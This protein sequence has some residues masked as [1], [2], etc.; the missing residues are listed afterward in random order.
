M[1]SESIKTPCRQISTLSRLS[2][3]SILALITIGYA[4]IS[5]ARKWE[6][7]L[8]L[9]ANIKTRRISDGGFEICGIYQGAYRRAGLEK[10]RSR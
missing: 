8:H 4:A 7:Y 3:G 5:L 6:V 1:S 9:F 2:A 10:I